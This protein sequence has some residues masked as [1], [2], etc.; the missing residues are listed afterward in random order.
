[1]KD[2]EN[3]YNL[4]KKLAVMDMQIYYNPDQMYYEVYI[5]KGQIHLFTA[6][7]YNDMIEKFKK[8]FTYFD[9]LRLKKMMTQGHEFF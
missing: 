2:I 7:N 6:F 1:M 5:N 8:N 3:P 4:E 9:D